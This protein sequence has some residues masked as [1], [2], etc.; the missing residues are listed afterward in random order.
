MMDEGTRY[1]DGSWPAK[2]AGCNTYRIFRPEVTE[3]AAKR[4]QLETEES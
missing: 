1:F 4:R 2:T 3:L